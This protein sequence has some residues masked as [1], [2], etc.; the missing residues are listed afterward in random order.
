MFANFTF[1]T[2]PV[3]RAHVLILGVRWLF[4]FLSEHPVFQALEMD[5]TY[6]TS[7]FAGNDQWV[8][9]IFL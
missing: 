7:A 3:E 5:E 2:L 1:E 6:G 8:L 4:L 9:G